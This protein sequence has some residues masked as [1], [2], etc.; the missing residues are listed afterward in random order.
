MLLII[1]Q[2]RKSDLIVITSYSIHYTK[3][4][5]K[6]TSSIAKPQQTMNFETGKVEELVIKGR[7][8][9]CVALRAPVI[10]EAMAAITMADLMLI[11]NK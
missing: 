10:V 5:E 7:H 8:D 2:Q 4:Y 6:P 1:T 11:E 3:L 9:A